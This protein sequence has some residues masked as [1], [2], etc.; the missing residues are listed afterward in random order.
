MSSSQELVAIADE[1]DNLIGAAPRAEMRQRNLIHRATYV[2]V[3]NRRG[4]LFVQ[5][6]TL[7][8]DIYPGYL[9]IAAGGVV[10]AGEPYDESAERELAE[11]LGIT[12]VP[13]MPQF[14]FFYDRPD[15]RVHGRVYACTYDGPMTLQA[16]EVASG[17]FLE[18]VDCLTR[19]RDRLTPD[20]VL[21][22]ERYL[23]GR[24]GRTP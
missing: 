8:K 17:E 10:L 24:E 6:R 20:G 5:E 18:P 11:E 4:R 14:A 23:A 7:T 9:D 22:L 1:A 12:G 21:V 16:E 3:F 19:L 13:L 2:L 15:N